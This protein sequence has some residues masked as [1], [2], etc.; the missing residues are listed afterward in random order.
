MYSLDNFVKKLIKRY[1]MESDSFKARS[2]V[3]AIYEVKSYDG[4]MGYITNF[5]SDITENSARILAVHTFDMDIAGMSGEEVV[6][7]VRMIIAREISDMETDIG[8][9]S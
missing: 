5:D 7:M 8:L 4:R 2:F 9:L 3:R 6:R 1:V